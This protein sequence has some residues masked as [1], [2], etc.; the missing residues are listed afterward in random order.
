MPLSFEQVLLY[1]KSA[2]LSIGERFEILLIG[3]EKR[4][5]NPIPAVRIPTEKRWRRRQ[6]LQLPEHSIGFSNIRIEPA[7]E[8]IHIFF[9]LRFGSKGKIGHA[10]AFIFT[11]RQRII[12]QKLQTARACGGGE[13]RGLAQVFFVIVEAGDQW[14]PERHIAVDLA[15]VAYIIQLCFSKRN[16]RRFCV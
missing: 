7:A 15:Q 2:L 10:D 13:A 12:A 4:G 5:T 8:T 11:A 16:A 1:T 14:R 9:C 6:H 3:K